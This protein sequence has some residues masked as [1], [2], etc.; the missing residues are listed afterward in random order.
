ML[1]HPN[2]NFI[3][4][5]RNSPN[6]DFKKRGIPRSETDE[7]YLGYAVKDNRTLETHIKGGFD[8]AVRLATSFQLSQRKKC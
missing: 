2:D 8:V 7:N 5:A 1:N 3:F 6:L 4:I